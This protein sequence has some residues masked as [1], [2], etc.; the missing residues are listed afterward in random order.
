MSV[1]P[2][3][4]AGVIHDTQYVTA[5]GG[6]RIFVQRWCPNGIETRAALVLSH[7]LG[8]HTGCYLP[9]VDY[10]A[11]RGAAIYAHDH[12]GFGRSEGLRG[13]VPSYARYVQD[14]KPLVERARAE[15]PGVPLVLVGHSM[16]GTIALLFALRYPELLD[17]AVFS[18]PALIVGLRVPPWKRLLGRTMSR[19]YPTYTSVGITRPAL[20][21]HD[22]EMQRFTAE[23]T[24]RH[25][26]VTARLYTEM[27]GRGPREVLARLGELRVPFLIVHGAEDPLVPIE[28]SRRVYDGAN[29]PGRAIRIYEGMRH[30]VFRETERERVFD[31]VAAWLAEQGIELYGIA[32]DN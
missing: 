10:F 20:L 7:G 6:E 24:L 19:L 12:R 23:D 26:R 32:S 1:T 30:E 3:Q 21:T 14:L 2:E 5:P 4:A 15:N 25:A 31:D 8:E 11:P 28:A 29:V 9:F 22:P 17:R 13:H 16:G 18:A 27:F